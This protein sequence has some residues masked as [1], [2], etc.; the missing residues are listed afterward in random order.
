MIHLLVLRG[1]TASQP[2][3]Q[4]TDKDMDVLKVLLLHIAVS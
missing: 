3:G 1:S 2:H 4:H